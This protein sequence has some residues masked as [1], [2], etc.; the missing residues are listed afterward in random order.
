MLD[1]PGGFHHARQRRGAHL[2]AGFGT[3]THAIHVLLALVVV[4]IS[5]GALAVMMGYLVETPQGAVSFV[6]LIMSAMFFNTAMMPRELYA[7]SLQPV[8]DLSPITAVAQ[9]VDDILVDEWSPDHLLLFLAW[10]IGLAGFGGLVL[11][12]KTGARRR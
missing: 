10:Y 2:G 8:V 7:S 5:S 4:A 3:L 12:L 6:P 1:Q 9:V 11:W